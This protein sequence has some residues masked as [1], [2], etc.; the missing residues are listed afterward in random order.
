MSRSFFFFLDKFSFIFFNTI[1]LHYLQKL[2]T[3]LTML[4]VE[5]KSGRAGDEAKKCKSPAKS[6]TVGISVLCYHSFLQSFS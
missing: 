1:T 6:R 3:L 4:I 5:V 2:P